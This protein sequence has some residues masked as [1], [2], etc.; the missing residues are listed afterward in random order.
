MTQGE[1]VKQVRKSINL[2]MDK[3]GERLGVTKTAISLIESGK[4][5]LTDANIKAICREFNVDYMWLTTGMGEMF[6]TADDDLMAAIDNIMFGENE[7]HK[8]L[9]KVVASM[10]DD[11]LKTLEHMMNNIADI[12]RG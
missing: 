2:T 4:N 8:K 7:F 10:N 3:F 1:R 6:R 11:D 12:M 5:N 9:F